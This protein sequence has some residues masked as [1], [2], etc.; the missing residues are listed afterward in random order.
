MLIYGKKIVLREKRLEDSTEDYSWRTDEELCKLDATRPMNVSYSEF[1][2]V[3][4]AELHAASRWSMRF[5]IDT[6][7]DKHIGNCMYYDIDYSRMQTELGIMI[8]DKEFWSHGYGTDAV[9]TLVNHIFRSTA[10]K[11]V[12]LH[13][14]EWNIRAQRCFQNSGFTALKRVKR[15]GYQFI[16]MDAWRDQWETWARNKVDREKP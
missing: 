13:T 15:S 2:N 3:Y 1:L 16:L 7:E 8:G 14:L 11:R 6:M 12:Y 9:S 10:M 4:R 5:S